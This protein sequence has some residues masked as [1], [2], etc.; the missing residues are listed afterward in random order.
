M[1]KLE[2]PE[3]FNDKWEYAKPP[4]LQEGEAKFDPVRISTMGS[5]FARNFIRWLVHYGYTEREQPWDILY[6]PFSIQKELERLYFEVPWEDNVLL[7]LSTSGEKRYRD[8]WRTWLV[9]SDKED[10]LTKNSEF[11]QKARMHLLDSSAFIITLGLSEVWS[12]VNKPE[13]VFN[14]VPIGSMRLDKRSWISRFAG[15]AEVEEALTRSVDIIR[16]QISKQCP[17]V[18]TLSPVP[19]KFTASSLSIREA[20]NLSKATL[21]VALRQL[22]TARND[23]EYFPSYEIVQSLSEKDGNNTWQLDGRH[24]TATVIETVCQAFLSTYGL[25]QPSGTR[26][27]FWVP[28]VDE[29][30]KVV[31]RLYS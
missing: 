2:Q 18:F 6:N 25:R 8:P 12:T 9:S 21:L 22:T 20:N 31:G 17:I 1:N 23:V 30:G 11:D 7:E 3:I 26:D 14:Q 29:D 13:I 28:K 4:T 19:L 27:K 16:E 5:C 10:L 24:V 15:V